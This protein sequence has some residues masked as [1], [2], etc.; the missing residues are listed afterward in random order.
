MKKSILFVV[1]I[2]CLSGGLCA[3]PNEGMEFNKK[4]RS[5]SPVE[6]IKATE[7]QS[8]EAAMLLKNEDFLRSTFLWQNFLRT[9]LIS[10]KEYGDI[11]AIKKTAAFETLQKICLAAT[12]CNKVL[13]QKILDAILGQE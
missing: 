7:A 13:L 3:G 2:I 10:Q 8:S 12:S 6:R 4:L 11:C 9:G 5:P 1:G